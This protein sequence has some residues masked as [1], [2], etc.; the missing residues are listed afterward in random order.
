[1]LEEERKAVE[2]GA[3]AAAMVKKALM[4]VENFMVAW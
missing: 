1:M 2:V 4:A 3:L